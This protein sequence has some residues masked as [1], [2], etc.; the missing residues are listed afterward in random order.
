MPSLTIPARSVTPITV[1]MQSKRS[2][3]RKVNTIIAISFVNTWDHSNLRKM[4]SIPGGT[5]KTPSNL[6]TLIGIPISAVRTI[7]QS[8]APLT[9]STSI[10]AVITI[11]IRPRSGAPDVMSPRLTRVAGL[12]TIMPALFKPINAI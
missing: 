8:N 2:T 6:V 12:S 10:T 1:P 4:G 11:P 7:P 5:L 3:N 9:L